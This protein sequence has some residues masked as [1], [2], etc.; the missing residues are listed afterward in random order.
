MNTRLRAAA[1]LDRVINQGQ[2]LT[3]VLDQ[4]LDTEL[5]PQDKAF[6]QALCYGV[7]RYYPQLDFL[8]QNL[9][10]RPLKSKDN[11]IRML[12][13]VGLYQL[14]FMRVKPHAAVAETVAAAGKKSW[15][16]SLLNAV[17]R[18]YQREHERLDALITNDRVAQTA[19]P[20]WLIDRMCSD[21]PEQADGLFNANNAPAPMVLRVNLRH[22]TADAYQRLLSECH[23]NSERVPFCS[24]ALV[25]NQAVNVELL[26]GFAEGW[27]SVQDAAAQLAAQL[28]QVEV[29]DEVLDL[30]AAPGGKTAA[31][32]EGQ[33]DLKHLVALDMDASRLLKVQQNLDRLKL[34]AEL[35]TLD[36]TDILAWALERQFNKILLDVPCSALGV[37]RRHPDIKLLRRT[38]D[39]EAL[40]TTQSRLLDAAWAVLKPGGRLLYATCSI[41]K[42]EN[43]QQIQRF[44]ERHHDAVSESWSVDWGLER[45]YGRQLLTGET[46]GFYYAGLLKSA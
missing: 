37:I 25:L 14:R 21:W 33:P 13:L 7:L 3:A 16:K 40:V 6:I 43:E 22:H 12:L 45:P 10:A 38:E 44:L 17:L 23:I 28:L 34:T 31:I 4:M 32:L 26:P 41:L 29:G 39:I 24:T 11:D 19:H 36:A 18:N 5:K 1:I 42:C 46:D 30:C 9:L 27:V 15:A 8:L 35:V 2:S 20:Q